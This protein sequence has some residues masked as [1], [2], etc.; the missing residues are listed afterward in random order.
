MLWPPVSGR[1]SFEILN[2]PHACRKGNWRHI[3]PYTGESVSFPIRTPRRPNMGIILINKKPRLPG[4]EQCSN[5]NDA[6]TFLVALAHGTKDDLAHLIR[7]HFVAG[8]A[9]RRERRAGR[10]ED[11]RDQQSQSL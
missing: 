5:A 11:A 8:E 1:K 10:V 2:E 7:L 4:C 3:K 6:L 9:K